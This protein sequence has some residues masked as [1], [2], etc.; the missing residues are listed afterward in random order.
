M[1]NGL[2][3]IS[4]TPPPNSAAA[5]WGGQQWSATPEPHAVLC[6]F[7]GLS[8]FKLLPE[9]VTV[10][11][12]GS[13]TLPS[14]SYTNQDLPT[15]ST[16]AGFSKVARATY[17][18]CFYIAALC[19][20]HIKAVKCVAGEAF[21]S[22]L[23]RLLKRCVN[24]NDVHAFMHMLLSSLSTSWCGISSIAVVVPVASAAVQ[25]SHLQCDCTATCTA[26]GHIVAQLIV[27]VRL[28]SMLEIAH[29]VSCIT[30]MMRTSSSAL[31]LHNNI[32]T[33]NHS[34]FGTKTIP[35]FSVR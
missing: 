35:L 14:I 34:Q 28:S 30:H 20:P 5:T 33:R 9:L 29:V 16:L 26:D 17:A 27:L 1:L 10:A 13:N 24:C 12:D 31:R 7:A 15:V 6:A 25:C 8:N 18:Q 4:S 22:I 21:Y 19:I 11:K 32:S 23:Q 2:P 3:Y